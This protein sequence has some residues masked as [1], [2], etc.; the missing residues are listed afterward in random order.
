MAKREKKMQDLENKELERAKAA[1]GGK[2]RFG[3]IFAAGGKGGKVS[4]A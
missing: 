4:G 2:K 1:K 3:G